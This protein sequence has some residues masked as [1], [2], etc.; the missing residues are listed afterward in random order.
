MISHDNIHNEVQILLQT[1]SEEHADKILGYLNG[2]NM[3]LLEAIT[4]DAVNAYVCIAENLIQK[5]EYH[6]KVSECINK[7]LALDPEHRRAFDILKL[8]YVYKSNKSNDMQ[9]NIE[10]LKQLLVYQPYDYQLQ[11]VIGMTYKNLN[12]CNHAIEHLKLTIAIIDNKKD[13]HDEN[14]L[15]RF[16]TDS[17]YTIAQIYYQLNNVHLCRYY[18]LKAYETD[19]K[20]SDVNNIMGVLYIHMRQIDKAIQHFECIPDDKK[21]DAI[22]TNLGSAYCYK[23]NYKKAIEYY[24]RIPNNLQAFQNKL[25]TSHYILDTIS[26]DMYMFELHKQINR[27]WP[28]AKIKSLHDY[29]KKAPGTKLKIGFVGGEYIYNNIRGVI[30]YFMHSILELFDRNKFDIVC[31]SVQPITQVQK[32][33]PDVVWK[34]V[35]DNIYT[36][37]LKNIIHNDGIDIMFDMAGHTSADRSD[38]FAIRAAPIQISYCAYPNTSGLWNMDYHIVDKYCDSDGISPG[39]GGVIRPNTQRYYTEKLIFMDN[40]FLNYTPYVDS[41][42]FLAEQA[43]VRNQYLTIGTFNKLNKINSRVVQLWQTIMQKCKSVH[44]IIKTKDLATDALREE[45]MQMFSDKNVHDRISILSYSPTNTD[46]LLEYNNIDLAMDT[47]PYSGT[48]TTC[49]ALYMGVPVMTLFDEKRQ[50]HVQNVSSSILINAGLSEFVCFS[51]QEYINKVIYYAN[52]LKE[53]HDIKNKIRNQFINTVCNGEAFVREFEQKMI[54]T[55]ENHI[56]H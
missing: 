36:Q 18:A 45:F 33:F 19:P 56:W 16:K 43:C 44:F 27:F 52:N 11:Y 4:D 49:D 21:T 8:N 34:H 15:L 50:Y 20:N 3:P 13:K 54:E 10:D 28:D 39:P 40:C 32:M 24:D 31:Y 37:E 22:Y 9:H 38:V 25:F 17:L 12:K 48:C 6:P 14:N 23:I 47:F 26:D 7:A 53:L 51:E 30:M 55:Y 29:I 41:P 5:Q 2:L 1:Y 35:H 46:H 42:L